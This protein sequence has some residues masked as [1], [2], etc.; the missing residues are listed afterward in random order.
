MPN[1]CLSRR[2]QHK[3]SH[4]LEIGWPY[5]HNPLAQNLVMALA[6]RLE[7]DTLRRDEDKEAQL[8]NLMILQNCKPLQRL[9]RNIQTSSE[10]LLQRVWDSD[11]TSQVITELVVSQHKLSASFY[12]SD[13]P[14][15]VCDLQH[16][17]R[18]LVWWVAFYMLKNKHKQAFIY[19]FIYSCTVCTSRPLQPRG[20]Q[21]RYSTVVEIIYIQLRIHLEWNQTLQMFSHGFPSVFLVSSNLLKT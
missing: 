13:K 18:G 8:Q 20:K 17:E 11:R 4:W 16:M 21:I 3:W 2:W 15:W 7:Q 6:G 9:W 1:S 19:L 5:Q 14:W 12:S 10:L